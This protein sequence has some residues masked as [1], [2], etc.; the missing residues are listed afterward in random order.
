MRLLFRLLAGLLVTGAAAAIVA[1]ALGYYLAARS[2]PDYDAS[3]RVQGIDGSI[4]IV[5]DANAVPHIL[6]TTD[7]DAAFALGWA[8]AQDRLW[9][10]EISRRTAQGRLAEIFGSDA[11]AIDRT[12]RA[13]D[14]LGY[15]RAAVARQTPEVRTWLEAYAGGVNARVR[16]VN[17]A[18]LGRGAPEFFL[19]GGEGLPPWTAEDT[20]SVIKLMALRLT[21]AAAREAWRARLL[22]HLTPGQIEDLDPSY[23]DKG[24]IALPALASPDKTP[25]LEEKRAEARPR[26][27]LS[28]FAE[29]G[30]GGASNAWA[31]GAGRAATGAPLLATDPHLWLS[32]PGVW[33]L[34]QITSPGFNAIGGAIPGIPA[35]LIGRNAAFGWGLTAAG[36]DDQD[37]YLE[38]VNPDDANQ[39]LTPDG[40]AAFRTRRETIHIDG[41]AAVEVTLRWTRHGPVTPEGGDLDFSSITPKGHVAALAWTALSADDGSMEAALNLMRAQ[42]VEDGA[43]ATAAHLAPAQNVI[44]ADAKGVGMVVA[45]VAPLRRGDSRSRGRVPSLGWLPE[46]DWVGRIPADAMPRAIRPLSDAVANANN[47]TTNAP[48]PENLSFDWGPPYRIRRIEQRLNDRPF[49]TRESFLEMQTDAVSEMARSVL[50]LIARDLWWGAPLAQGADAPKRVEALDMLAKWNGEMSGHDPEPLIFSAWMRALTRRLAEDEL[51]PLFPVVA[52][53]RP[54]FVER[55]FHDVDGAARWCDVDKTP[56]IETC[57]EISRRA[58][59]DAL[60]ELAGRYGDDMK[61]WRWGAAHRATHVHMPLGLFRGLGMLVNINQ[62]TSGGDHSIMIGA[63]R[64]RGADPYANVHAAGL[65]AVYDFADLDRSV[66]VISTGESGHPLSRH[67]DDLAELWRRGDTIPMSLRP[68]DARAGALGTTILQPAGK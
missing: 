61:A 38:K 62:E 20:M 30:F 5:R 33:H 32:A 3:W 39:Y 64:G 26:S 23:P 31:V 6:A 15:A 37:I 29:P 8:H 24:L 34:A 11:L 57:A 12:M 49:H 43:H 16:A 60:A 68:D 63:T 36:I 65:R 44:M 67:Y 10:M 18:A 51:G 4:E 25:G 52:G 55:V 14:L 66:F 22:T 27:P 21:D 9:Q 47:R 53:A 13:L 19:F 40:W 2:L 42:A 56:A 1:A 7:K 28:P 59:D 35:I 17:E 45:G 54:L 50:P 48:F 46:N 58:L 41:G